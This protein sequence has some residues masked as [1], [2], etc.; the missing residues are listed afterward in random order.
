MDGYL[1]A[2]IEGSEKVRVQ[3]TRQY[4]R[5]HFLSVL[6]SRRVVES[7]TLSPDVIEVDPSQFL[8]ALFDELSEEKPKG[9]SGKKTYESI[10]TVRADLETII[11]SQVK[12][13]RLGAAKRVG[14]TV[15]REGFSVALQTTVSVI[16]KALQVTG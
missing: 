8:K 16:L 2:P 7:R 4:V 12:D 5:E 13:E 9:E 3:F 10:E 6:R 14:A 11:S 1:V 15:A